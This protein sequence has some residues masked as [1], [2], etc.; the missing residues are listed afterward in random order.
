MSTSRQTP[1]HELHLAAGAQ[2]EER[3]GWLLPTRYASLEEE[4]GAVRGG[5]GLFDRSHLEVSELS[6]TGVLAWLRTLLANDVGRLEDGE[7]LL[8]CLCD[9]AGGVLDELIVCRLA[10]ERWLVFGNPVPVAGR[11]ALAEADRPESVALVP[12]GTRAL[13]AVQGPAALEYSSL[14]LAVTGEPALAFAGLDRLELIEAG[15]LIVMRGGRTGEDGVEILLPA[16]SAPA[17]W[18]AL[19]EAGARPC[20]DDVHEVLR[21]EA[22]MCRFGNELD[23]SRTPVESGLGATVDLA[24]PER[25][26]AGRETLE[27]QLRFGGCG[28]LVGLVY[29]GEGRREMRTGQRVQLAGRDVGTITSATLSPVLERSIALARVERPFKGNCDVVIDDHPFPASTAVLPFVRGGGGM[30][31]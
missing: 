10:A 1:L 20:G 6:G 2:V 27:D 22:G 28:A 14:A 3:G 13:L 29:E 21:I 11:S 25:A 31:D 9:E 23:A 16:A 12:G 7:A 5:A 17:L 24:D 18:T 30:D 4:H 8:G 26:F 19:I 15:E